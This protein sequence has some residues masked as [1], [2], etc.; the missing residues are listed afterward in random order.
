MFYEP[1]IETAGREAIRAHQARR[2]AAMLAE[3]AEGNPFYAG[4]WRRAGVDP[5]AV[6]SVDDL[7]LLPMTGKAEV[8]AD[9][10]A[11]PPFGTNLTYPIERY[12]RLHQTSGTTA[13]P[14]RW[15]DTRESWA[16]WAR[17]WG[18]VYAA[19]GVAPGDRVYL[20]FSFG[21]FIGFWSA[22][23]GA[24]ALGAMAISGGGLTSLQRLQAILA[25]RATVVVCTPTYALRLREVAAEEG[26]AL[27]ASAVR[28]LIHAGEPGASIP[29]T[30]RL[31][32]EGWGATCYDHAG[33]TEA[34]AFAYECEPRPGRVHLNE[35]E[36][37]G[38]VVDPRTL[39][40]VGPGERGELI[41]TNL[42]R[43]GMPAI[44]Y[45]TGDLVEL[46]PDRCPCGRTFAALRGG[47]LGRADDMLIVRGVNVFPS[48]IEDV[49]RRFPEVAEFQIEVET[50]RE[51]DE[52]VIRLDARPGRGEA[53]RL[54][55]A[56][57]QELRHRLSLRAQVLVV[58]PGT[59]PRYELKAKRLVRR[60]RVEQTA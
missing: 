9:Q 8:A 59:L 27:R 6:R 19:A 52:L 47:I 49:I 40:P 13:E 7:P 54:V 4:K 37:I 60:A 41:V 3:L 35:A 2:L 15:L 26:I 18:F 21:P 42:G 56:V 11:H 12:V 50:A 48:A 39:R 22:F 34:G 46:A 43:V 25:T 33:M 55:E 29:A 28:A 16:W 36:F 20:A 1:A 57:G 10:A 32:E 5:R 31:I 30:R 51:M 24:E 58:D 45:R 23:A 53:W 38:E 17:C 14:I 44:R